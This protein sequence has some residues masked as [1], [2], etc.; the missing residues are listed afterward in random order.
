MLG[1]RLLDYGVLGVCLAWCLVSW[2][3]LGGVGGLLV[4][5]CL[6]LGVLVASWWCVVSWWCRG[7]VLVM[8]ASLHCGLVVLLSCVVLSCCLVVLV[9]W[10]LT[11]YGGALVS[12]CRL[13]IL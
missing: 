13:E 11:A 5:F 1:V 4:V 3:S 10:C 6:V 8:V 2:W 9:S 12:S 7:G